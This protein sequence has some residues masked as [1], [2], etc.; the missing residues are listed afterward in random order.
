MRKSFPSFRTR[1][2]C[3]CLFLSICLPVYLPV[4]LPG[5][6]HYKIKI[7]IQIYPV[8][9]Y[10][11]LEIILVSFHLTLFYFIENSHSFK[12]WF[13]IEFSWKCPRTPICFSGPMAWCRSH[14]TF[15]LLSLVL[16][17]P[18]NSIQ[19]SSRFYWIFPFDVPLLT[20]T[21]RRNIQE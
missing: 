2:Q 3:I 20:S 8:V 19:P 6:R 10:L 12:N 4:Y 7:R 5:F 1:N 11:S 13:H 18:I 14:F 9:V 15:K 16:T 17:K 21:R